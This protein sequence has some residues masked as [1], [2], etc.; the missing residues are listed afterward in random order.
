MPVY[1]DSVNVDA[2][3]L[4]AALDSHT[5][6]HTYACI[7][8]DP[9]MPLCCPGSS[10]FAQILGVHSLLLRNLCEALRVLGLQFLPQLANMADVN[11]SL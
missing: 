5:V 6:L 3:C 4:V 1:V 2:Q 8:F 10:A 7:A 9:C 11:L